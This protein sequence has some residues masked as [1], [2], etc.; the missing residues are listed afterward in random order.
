MRKVLLVLPVL[1]TAGT[2]LWLCRMPPASQPLPPR[3]VVTTA[4]HRA[5]LPA[6]VPGVPGEP[7]PQPPPAPDV[8]AL[9]DAL[10]SNKLDVKSDA[11]RIRLEE[12]IPSRLYGEAARCYKGGL[13]RDKKLKLAFR[14]QVMDGEISVAEAKVVSSTMGDSKLERCIEEE[15]RHA[16]WHDNVM[17]DWESSE[18]LLMRV[19][20]FKQYLEPADHEG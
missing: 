10:S 9:A 6:A 13:H 7:A 1:L 4:P 17:P 19:R 16:H 3:P 11:F 18:E 5:P 12:M 14:L 20:G 2:A 15:V 8:A